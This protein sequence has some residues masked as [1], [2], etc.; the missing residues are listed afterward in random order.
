MKY[1]LKNRFRLQGLYKRIFKTSSKPVQ[2]KLCKLPGIKANEKICNFNSRT[3]ILSQWP[4]FLF[5]R[6]MLLNPF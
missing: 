3:F 1:N 4:N 6:M 2:L 5:T